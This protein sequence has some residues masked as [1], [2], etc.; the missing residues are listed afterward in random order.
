MLLLASHL[1]LVWLCRPAFKREFDHSGR[2][3]TAHFPTPEAVRT[4]RRVLK[5]VSGELWAA[6]GGGGLQ[7]GL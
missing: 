6:P 2:L 4:P 1:M 5:Y 7:C 3:I